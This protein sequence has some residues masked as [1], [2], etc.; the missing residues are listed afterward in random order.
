MVLDPLGPA[1]RA[2]DGEFGAFVNFLWILVFP[3]L[4]AAQHSTIYYLR[5]TCDY[6]MHSFSLLTL[7]LASLGVE[8]VV[9]YLDGQ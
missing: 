9:L 4:C 6:N 2:T 3:W 1:H 8:Y 7:L 5:G